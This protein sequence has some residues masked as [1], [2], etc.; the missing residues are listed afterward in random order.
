MSAEPNTDALKLAWRQQPTSGPTISL[1]DLKR[2]A[3]RF[4]RGIGIRNLVEYAAAVIV[5]ISY[6]QMMLKSEA[7]LV[8]IGC[9]LIVIATLFVVVQIHVRLSSQKAPPDALGA[10][11]VDY[12]RTA[13]LRQIEG[14]RGIARWYMAPFLPGFSLFILTSLLNQKWGEAFVMSAMLAFVML[15]GIWLNHR[16]A[17]RLE[18]KLAE[19]EAAIPGSELDERSAA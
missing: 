1:A 7:M 16:G 14:L 12:H 8:K 10:S 3:G 6:S 19:L 2:G 11:F 13:V 4:Q 5:V 9:V 17:L 15:G 18:R